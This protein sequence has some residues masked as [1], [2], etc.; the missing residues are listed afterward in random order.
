MFEFSTI[1]YNNPIVEAANAFLVLDENRIIKYANRHFCRMTGYESEELKKKSIYR[2][3]HSDFPDKIDNDLWKTVNSKEMWLGEIQLFSKDRNKIWVFTRVLPVTDASGKIM[4]YV[5]VSNNI[6]KLKLTEMELIKAKEEAEIERT[7][8]MR[9]NEAKSLLFASITH[10]LRTPLNAIIGYSDLILDERLGEKEKKESIENIRFS[11]ETLRELVDDILDYSQFEKGMVELE[12]VEF[13]INELIKNVHTSLKSLADMKNLEFICEF[14]SFESALLGDAKRLRQVLI[15]LLGNAVKYTR[16]GHIKFK[17]KKE[18]E[19][20]GQIKIYFEIEDTGIG[21]QKDK[22]DAIF[23]EFVRV[24]TVRNSYAGTGLGLYVSKKII[25]LYGG[26]IKAESKEGE[27]SRFYFSLNFKKSKTVPFN[28]EFN[29]SGSLESPYTVLLIDRDELH[30]A[31]L[32][33]G[34]RDYR[35]RYAY[36][37]DEVMK[38]LENEKIDIV[39]SEIKLPNISGVELMEKIKEKYKYLPVFAVTGF[40]ESTDAHK[41]YLKMGFDGYMPKPVRIS[42][43]K[44]MIKEHLERDI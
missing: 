4:E 28:P 24:E 14:D 42:K 10:D 27:G 8:A 29:I 15:N 30:K 40:V 2:I 3:Y 11:A 6:T 22:L 35:I 12:N 31:L 7:K 26:K 33:I 5:F 18:K 44:N 16:K 34:L 19:D 39:L 38:I 9:A 23:D 21:I 1:Y 17:V 13:D 25:E 36:D 32:S 41:E 43:L 37:V 20:K